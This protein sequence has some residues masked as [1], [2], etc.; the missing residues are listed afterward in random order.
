LC[1]G[2][3]PHT[4]RMRAGEVFVGLDDAEVTRLAERD[5]VVKL[6]VR[7]LAPAAAKGVDGAT[8]VAAPAAGANAAGIGVF[9]TGGLG[10]VHRG[11]STS[12]DE[13]ADLPALSR[14]PVAVVC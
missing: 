2:A 11:A 3:S 4:R 12:Y 6:S 9:A 13:S 1:D 7:D 10:G 14:L 5:D 8:T